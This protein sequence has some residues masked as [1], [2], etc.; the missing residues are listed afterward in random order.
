MNESFLLVLALAALKYSLILDHRFSMGDKSG[1][2][3]D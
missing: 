3:S 2:A 1:K